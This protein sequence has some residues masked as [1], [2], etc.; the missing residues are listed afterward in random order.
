[1]NKASYSTTLLWRFHSK[2][3]E[4]G[5]CHIW[6]GGTSRGYG[7]FY[8]NGKNTGAHRMAHLIYKG[9]IPAGLLVCHKCDNPMCVNP[10]HLFLGTPKKNSEDMVAKGRQARG[11][12]HGL[13]KNPSRISRGEKHYSKLRP[14]LT[15]KGERN[16]ASKLTQF[17]VV[18]IRRRAVSGI[19]HREIAE[20]FNVDR[21]LVGLIVN[22]KTW[23]HIQ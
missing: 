19:T 2:I 23:K 14:E 9:E 11:E 13:V 7:T 4:D 8:F 1:M 22:R 3:K 12:R 20:D 10:D 21:S 18:E 5:P 15:L 6:T 17:D 16:P